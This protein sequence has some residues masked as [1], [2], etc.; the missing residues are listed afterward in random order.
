MTESAFDGLPRRRSDEE[1]RAAIAAD[2]DA[3]PIYTAEQA[4]LLRAAEDARDR[5]GIARLRR[6][7]GLSQ[8]QFANRY[9]IPLS[10][11]RQWEQG[12]RE[13]DTATRLLIAVIAEDPALVASV[14][15]RVA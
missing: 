1:I 12:T 6:K 14:A 2:P 5:F 3:A 8:V 10:T 4:R 13:P 11:L 7:L 15:A 9:R